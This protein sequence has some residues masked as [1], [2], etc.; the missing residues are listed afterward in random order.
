MDYAAAGLLDGLEGSE[1]DQR[2][3]LLDSLSNAGFSL[4][5]LKT[6]D[7]EDR[8]LLLPLER[9]LAGRYSAKEIEQ[10]TGLP[11]ET[12]LRIRRSLGLPGAGPEEPMFWDADV[13]AARSLRTFIDAGFSEDSILEITRVLGEAMARV[14]GASGAAFTRTFLQPGESEHD[15]AWRFA[16][17]AEQL[18]PAFEPVLGAAYRAHLLDNVRRAMISRADLAEGRVAPEVETTVC[19]AD[20]VGFTRLGSEL[21]T[22]TL[23]D[24]VG[25]FGELAAD[26]AD[27]PVRLVKTIGDAAMLASREPAPLVEAALTLVE[28][29]EAADLPAVRAGLALGPAIGLAGDLYGH[30]VNLASRVTG[31][32]RPGSVLCTK[33]IHDAAP[34]FNWSFA[35]AHRFKGI[36]DSVPLYRAR[37]PTSGEETEINERRAGRRRR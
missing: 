5:E 19:F 24:V 21:E 13:E 25:A 18:T 33:E 1:R 11:A 6:A 17:L 35:G 16:E 29:V 27:G 7:D 31:I 9:V 26:A 12:M 37:R 34:D 22:Q 15:V 3:R 36:A 14:S 2:I 10:R 20:L 8:L 28:A 30:A 23:G 4:D 32:A